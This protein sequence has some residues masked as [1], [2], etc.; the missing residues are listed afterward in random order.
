MTIQADNK[1]PSSV[2]L[3]KGYNMLLYFTGSMIMYEPTM[4]CVT[5]FFAGGILRQ[6][7]VSSSNPVFMKASSLL[8][9]PCSDREQC[10]QDLVK[11]YR[12]LFSPEGPRLAMPLASLYTGSILKNTMPADPGEFYDSYGWNARKKYNV[13]GDHLGIELLFLT[14]LIEK[15]MQFDDEPCRF[16]MKR[17][18][19]RFISTHLMPW[20]QGWNDNV[21]TFA[22]T[23]YYKGIGIL[24][25]ACVEDLDG[26]FSDQG[27]LL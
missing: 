16:E 26:I 3:L 17:E 18:I 25:V 1:N 10:R 9:E 23:G 8:R 24:L 19:R 20:I 12:R 14:V 7:P 13:P 2:N 15:L 11:D 22:G 4:E 6:L 5:D 21:Q 27:R